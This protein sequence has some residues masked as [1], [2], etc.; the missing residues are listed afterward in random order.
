MLSGNYKVYTLQMIRMYGL[1]Y[2]EYMVNDKELWKYTQKDYEDMVI[3]RYDFIVNKK[4]IIRKNQ[5]KL[6][7]AS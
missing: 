2:V 3:E 5:E 7:D 1:E 4:E 6:N